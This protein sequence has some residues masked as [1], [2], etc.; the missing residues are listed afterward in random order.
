M[1]VWALSAYE[2]IEYSRYFKNIIL[3]IKIWIYKW[4][5]VEI[6]TFAFICDLLCGL[7]MISMSYGEII[8]C[9]HK[10]FT[11]PQFFSFNNQQ[12]D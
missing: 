2:E 12:I 3:N 8:N 4:L 5:E 6:W 11:V 7:P 1:Y 10:G 9:D